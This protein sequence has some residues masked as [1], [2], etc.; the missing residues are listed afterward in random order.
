MR[1]AG[2]AAAREGVCYL[3]GGA[4]A[5]LLGWRAT[6]I[7]VDLR[8]EPGA[9]RGPASAAGNQERAG[10][11]RRARLAGRLRPAAARLAGT[12]HQC[13][14][15]GPALLR[16]LRSLLAGAV[17]ARAWTCS[18]SRGRRRD[19]EARARRART[20]A[21]A[22]RGDRAGALSV[23]VARAG[24]DPRRRRNGRSLVGA[25]SAVTD[26]DEVGLSAPNRHRHA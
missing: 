12:Q 13:Q 9:G 15:G 8:L 6:T 21:R 24:A 20:T 23:S 1:A 10:R 22:P 14:E 11:Q 16:R 17:Q 18:R 4:T 5:V 3:T 2:E 26:R 25:W 7:D 19:D